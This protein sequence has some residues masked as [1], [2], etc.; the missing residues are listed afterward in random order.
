HRYAGLFL[1][2][3]ERRW[4]VPPVLS[5][6]ANQVQHDPIDLIVFGHMTEDID[7]MFIGGRMA[8]INHRLPLKAVVAVSVFAEPII[9]GAACRISMAVEQVIGSDGRRVLVPY[10]HTGKPG[11]Y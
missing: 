6:I 8:G 1:V 5:H 10:F 11:V 4:V 9:G 7:Q 2:T 3:L